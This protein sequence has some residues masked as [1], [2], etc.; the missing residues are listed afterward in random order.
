MLVKSQ[1]ILP[2]PIISF[3]LSVS[4]Q[5]FNE[6]LSSFILIQQKLGSSFASSSCAIQYFSIKAKAIVGT[7][8]RDRR[9]CD[10]QT[11]TLWPSTSS[12]IMQ[13]FYCPS[14]LCLP[15]LQVLIDFLQ[16]LWCLTTGMSTGLVA[17]L[18]VPFSLILF[19]KS[20]QQY[21]VQSI[22]RHTCSCNRF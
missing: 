16:L 15:L 7:L 13:G 14:W 10:V 17:S 1:L 19:F 6:Y 21:V 9:L 11:C 20:P 3:N 2:A 5:V 8:C 18:R 12:Y 22:I 4:R